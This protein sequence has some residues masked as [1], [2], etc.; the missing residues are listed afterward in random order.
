MKNIAPEEVMKQLFTGERQTGA[1][2]LL[3]RMEELQPVAPVS[4]N[5]CSLHG[6]RTVIFYAGPACPYCLLLDE[7]DFLREALAAKGGN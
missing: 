5:F 6:E 4:A 2:E 3:R 1:F 7:A